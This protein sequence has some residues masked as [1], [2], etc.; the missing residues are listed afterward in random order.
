MSRFLSTLLSLLL[1]VPPVAAEKKTPSQK[2]REKLVQMPAGAIVEVVQPDGRWRGRLGELGAE[3]FQVQV[4]AKDQIHQRGFRYAD[5]RAVR[6]LKP[7]MHPAAR[8]TVGILAGIGV[9][10]LVVLV[11]YAAYGAD[12]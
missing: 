9:Y 10:M 12:S 6:I 5:V 2:I 4:A 7:G 3:S 1:A 11:F 8:I